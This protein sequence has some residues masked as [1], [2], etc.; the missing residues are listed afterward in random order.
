M[1]SARAAE[2]ERDLIR[3]RTQAGLVAAR[4][5]GKLGGRRKVLS[6]RQVVMA[7]KLY[8]DKSNTIA[9]ICRTLRVSRSTLYRALREGSQPEES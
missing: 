2:F 3:E 5:R 6:D 1:S 7:R 4:A 9:D 8:V